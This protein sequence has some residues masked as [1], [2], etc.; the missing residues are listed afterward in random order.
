MTFHNWVLGSTKV[1]KHVISKEKNRNLVIGSKSIK[2]DRENTAYKV[3][4]K[5][6]FDLQMAFTFFLIILWQFSWWKIMQ[7]NT[8]KKNY[9]NNV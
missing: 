6:K 3:K 5:H 7:N 8:D 1:W 2:R 9:E 4:A